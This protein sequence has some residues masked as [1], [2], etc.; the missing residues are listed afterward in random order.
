[1][2]EMMVKFSVIIDDAMI[3]DLLSTFAAVESAAAGA[4]TDC[5]GRVPGE[6]VG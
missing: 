3:T 2:P 1:M 5:F 4:G 6:P